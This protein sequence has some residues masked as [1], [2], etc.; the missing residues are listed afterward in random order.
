MEPCWKAI[1]MS[2]EEQERALGRLILEKKNIQAA[3]GVLRQEI[4][5]LGKI[6]YAI[7][8]PLSG[9]IAGSSEET[10]NVLTNMELLASSGGMD[11]L[12]DHVEQLCTNL[13]RLKQ[14][15]AAIS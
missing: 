13:S 8:A 10:A 6:V 7:G 5:R 11:K 15:D 2:I 12:K 4:G 14:I 1:H 3:M 9:I